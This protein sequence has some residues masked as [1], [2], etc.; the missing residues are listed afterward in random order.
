MIPWFSI[1]AYS[2]AWSFGSQIFSSLGKDMPMIQLNFL[3]ATFAF[4]LFLIVALLGGNLFI[5]PQ[6]I[7]FLLLSGILGFA[8]ADLF[9]FY[10][11]AH[12]G[13]SRTLM[14]ASFAP[15][16]IA[17]Q[18]YFLLGLTLSFS[19]II[20]IILMISCVFFLS[21][22]KK[23]RG[24]FSWKLAGI[25]F[26]GISL[27]SLGVIFSKKAF[28]LDPH[29]GGFSANVY[30]VGIAVV[31]LFLLN[32][33]TRYSLNYF[34]LPSPKLK[35]LLIATILGNFFSLGMYLQAISKTNPAIVSGIGGALAPIIASICEHIRKKEPPT[36][37]FL[38]GVATMIG[39]AVIFIFF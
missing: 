31:F 5:H 16:L 22:E 9:L 27:D 3:K 37:W 19:K 18:A 14:L 11:L 4:F 23:S 20:G 32:L 2:S 8:I 28:M 6:A 13:A 24:S 17:L 39:G 25:A 33:K 7:F 26:I 12:L 15:S 35:L 10:A 38:T 29:L 1:I 21:F 34:H 30:R 36:L